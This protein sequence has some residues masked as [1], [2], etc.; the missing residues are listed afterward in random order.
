MAALEASLAK[1]GSGDAAGA[2]TAPAT[3]KKR[4]PVEKAAAKKA[5]AAKKPAK[6]ATGSRRSA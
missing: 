6:K 2:G 5:T 3:Q 1:T 4:A